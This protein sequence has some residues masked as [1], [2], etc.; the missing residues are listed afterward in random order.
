MARTGQIAIEVFKMTSVMSR[1]SRSCS[2]KLAGCDVEFLVAKNIMFDSWMNVKKLV[3]E[4]EFSP[5]V[6]NDMRN[7]KIHSRNLKYGG[8]FAFSPLDR[9]H[10]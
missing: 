4:T 10:Y 8:Y 9:V 1:T 2:D 7:Q 3:W 6:T 5:Y